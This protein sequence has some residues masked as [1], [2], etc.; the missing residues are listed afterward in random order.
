MKTIDILFAMFFISTVIAGLY[1]VGQVDR[2]A[3]Q[4]SQEIK[5]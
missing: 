2:F 1:V 3:T 4:I 5:R